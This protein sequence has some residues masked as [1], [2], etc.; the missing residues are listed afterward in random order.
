MGQP[1]APAKR[2]TL[3]VSYSRKDAKW[4]DMLLPFLAPLHRFCDVQVWSDQDLR[5]GEDWYATIRDRLARTRYALCLVSEHFLASSFCIDEELPALFQ[6]RLIGGVEIVPLFI[7]P[8]SWRLHPWLRR[9][10]GR[11]SDVKTFSELSKA[12]RARI[13]ADLADQLAANFTTGAPLFERSPP[14]GL[15]PPHCIDLDRLPPTVDLLLGRRDEWN[16]LDAA[17]T[18]PE[19][20]VVVLRA[21]GGVGKSTLAGLWVRDRYDQGLPGFDRAFVWSFY[22]QGTREQAASADLFIDTALRFFSDPDPTAGDP[23]DKGERLAKFVAAQR[24]L[25]VLDG[26]EPMQAEASDHALRGAIKDPSLRTLLECLARDNPG[27]CLVT[28]REPLVDLKDM[29][30]VS[31]RPLDT[32]S[33]VACRALLRIAGVAGTDGELEAAAE[34][35]GRHA[36]AV[37][38]LGSW[39]H[40][41]PG[42]QVREAVRLPALDDVTIEAGRH[43]RRVME[44]WAE[45]LRARGEGAALELLGVL[46]LFDRPAERAAVAAVLG[47]D[48][49]AGLNAR[50]AVSGALDAAL[51]T[52]RAAGLVARARRYGRSDDEAAWEIDAHPL[53]REHFGARLRA[54]APAAWQAGHERLYRHVAGA[55]EPQPATLAGMEPLFRAVHHGCAAGLYEEALN[56]VY[57]RRIRRGGE[58][59][60]VY[61]LG[62][63]AAD[64]TALAGFFTAPWQRPQPALTARD[65]AW[66]LTGAGFALRALGRL[67]DAVA[68]MEAALARAVEQ[69]AW[70][71]AAVDA[72]N[73][74]ELLLTLGRL[75]ETRAAPPGAIERAREAIAHAD[76]S[77]DD[78]LRLIMHTTLAD[79]L[80][81]R[82]RPTEAQALF[83]EAEQLQAG[84]QPWFPQLYSLG[85]YRYG[86]LLLTLG[87]PAQA[88]RRAEHTMAWTAISP[89][90]GLLIIALDHLLLGRAALATAPDPDHPDFALARLHLNAA[91]TGLRKAGD[92]DFIAHGLLA[93]AA[94]HRLAADWPAAHRDLAE[95][96][97]IATRGGMRL[98]LADHHLES[99]RLHLATGDRDAARTAYTAARAEVEAI[100]YHRR[101]PELAALAAALAAT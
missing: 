19:A 43:P 80:H 97:R 49:V 60:T 25:L 50:L 9:L 90:A 94:L 32:L 40:E 72:G 48:P 28:T 69:A 11:P 53:V 100:G 82:G 24:T 5:D 3:F 65:Q 89:E 37:A 78:G 38:L 68:P 16:A 7:R 87:E 99:A 98:F 4:R 15:P 84:W 46:G 2:D 74:A 39:L 17:A 70:K 66:V 35:L 76:R 73:L 64:L 6:Q 13:W 36:L 30:G 23:W 95:A 67:S 93:R 96:H 14:P 12:K 52:L 31:D 45:R 34:A 63:F 77:G 91:V 29:A 58:H 92:Q 18:D 41:Q 57:H 81:Q 61:K 101:D 47:G 59:Y 33:P 54:A 86:D 1:A 20:R 26:L 42:R 27:L 88:R 22:S 8:C 55:A 79:A 51:A 56:A 62:A 85:G 44:A 71:G 21:P 75:G 83:V 10:N